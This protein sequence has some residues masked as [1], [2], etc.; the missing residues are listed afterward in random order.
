M[1]ELLKALKWHWT[2]FFALLTGALVLVLVTRLVVPSEPMKLFGEA[3]TKKLKASTA[4]SDY[5]GASVRSPATAAKSKWGSSRP[6]K[7]AV[8]PKPRPRPRPRPRPSAPKT[9]LDR[10]SSRLRS[11]SKRIVD[12]PRSAVRAVAPTPAPDDSEEEEEEEEED[13]DTEDEV[14]DPEE[15]DE[16]AEEGEPPAAGAAT[17][18]DPGSDADGDKAD[19][20]EGDKTPSKPI[21]P[22]V[23]RRVP[24]VKPRTN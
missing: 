19:E 9:D 15:A 16:A 4:K 8:R 3:T 14:D 18:S 2:P 11:S 20:E 21:R 1:A 22:R 12:R 6:S 10:S 24:F 17:G 23:I 5:L 7:P 13:P